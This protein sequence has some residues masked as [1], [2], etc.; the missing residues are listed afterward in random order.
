MIGKLKRRKKT[1]VVAVIFALSF[2]FVFRITIILAVRDFIYLIRPIWDR[3]PNIPENLIPHFYA[4]GIPPQNLCSL[5]GWTPR[6][7]VVDPEPKVIDAFI[8][9]IEIDL[10][11]IRLKELWN[12]V[13]VFVI[14]EA[15]KTFTGKEKPL[16]FKDNL[17]RFTW[18]KEKLLHFVV[19]DLSET[20][21]K[22]FENESRMRG[23][24]N[25]FIRQVNPKSGDLV[26]VGDIDEIPFAH[27]IQLLKSCNGFPEEI[28]LEVQN[29]VYSFEFK[30]Q[31]KNWKPHV[32]TYDPSKFQYHH[33]KRGST[34]RLADAGWHCSFCFRH[35]SDFVFKMTSYSH[36]DRVT[37]TELLNKEEI[38]RKICEGLDIYDMLPEAYTFKELVS[39]MGKVP[40]TFST[41]GIPK[42]IVENPEK[43]KFLLPEGCMRD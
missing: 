42:Y 17:D 23:Y 19:S 2:A 18:A 9:S 4:E 33:G 29:Y 26:I 13:D 40:K 32:T 38:Q 20:P 22:D 7:S 34:H 5:H 30:L 27:T 16:I 37:K 39:Q 12:V 21:K 25:S 15:D 3:P 1:V 11:E 41:I 43:F 10:L 31:T 14:V 6:D 35:I 24:I 36:S 28:H 8:F